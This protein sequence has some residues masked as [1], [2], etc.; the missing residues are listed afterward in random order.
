MTDL[1]W[2]DT[3]YTERYLGLPSENADVYAATSLLTRAAR[4]ERPLLIIHGLADDNDLRRDE[5]LRKRK[6]EARA[7]VAG[8]GRILVLEKHE[9]ARGVGLEDSREE[10]VVAGHAT[11]PSFSQPASSVAQ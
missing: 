3:A 2:Y 11:T 4:L 8:E 1:R 9:A 5:L 7:E 10:V 6:A